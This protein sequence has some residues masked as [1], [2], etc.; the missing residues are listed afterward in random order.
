M[1]TPTD[2]T[3]QPCRPNVWYRLVHGAT[4]L[5]GLYRHDPQH[6]PVFV[7]RRGQPW[8]LGRDVVIERIEQEKRE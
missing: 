1:N 2:S 3:G 5:I 6:G 8:R 7:D 4:V